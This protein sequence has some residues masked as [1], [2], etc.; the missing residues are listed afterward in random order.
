MSTHTLL[1]NNINCLP[2]LKSLLCLVSAETLAQVKSIHSK[3]RK[4]PYEN[5]EGYA[6][7]AGYQF[8][9]DTPKDGNCMFHALADQLERVKSHSITH[10][11]LRNELVQ[12]LSEN[13]NLVSQ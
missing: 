13:P 12:H 8:R 11:N 7:L 10:I 6:Q 1:H 5:L 4:I 3:E 9:G 2:S